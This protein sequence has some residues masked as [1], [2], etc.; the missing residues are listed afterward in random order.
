MLTV[1]GSNFTYSQVFNNVLSSSTQNDKSLAVSLLGPSSTSINMSATVR[2]INNQAG[3]NYV[4]MNDIAYLGTPIDESSASVCSYTNMTISGNIVR[5]SIPATE[6]TP[7]APNIDNLT[8]FSG[9]SPTIYD[10]F[11]APYDAKYF[12]LASS[13]TRGTYAPTLP[14]F[15]ATARPYFLMKITTTAAMPSFVL[16][17]TNS[18]GIDAIRV[19][20]AALGTWYNAL[21]LFNA[22]GCAASSYLPGATRFPITLPQGL[23]LTQSSDIYINVQFSGYLAASGISVAYT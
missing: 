8:T 5:M 15:G 13:I 1:N 22:G 6:G 17:L 10:S 11:Y 2:N 16:Y 3:N 18:S 4:I 7:L 21:T 9:T 23:S 14:S 19:Q 20:W 12:P